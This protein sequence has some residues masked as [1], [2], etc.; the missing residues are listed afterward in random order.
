MGNRDGT[1]WARVGALGRTSAQFEHDRSA[2]LA[3]LQ[4]R[5]RALRVYPAEFVALVRVAGTVEG[6]GMTGAH[7]LIPGD[8]ALGEVVVEVRA[9]PGRAAEAA[10]HPSP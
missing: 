2:F 9:T 5:D 6:P 7:E 1:E 4:R 10:V 8:V 3:D